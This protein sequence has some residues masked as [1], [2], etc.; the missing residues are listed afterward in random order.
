[1]HR[2]LLPVAARA[3]IGGAGPSGL[4]HLYGF[5]GGGRL[6]FPASS[7]F[8][9]RFGMARPFDALAPATA[10]DLLRCQSLESPPR[11]L[12]LVV[13]CVGVLLGLSDEL[14]GWEGCVKL[15]KGESVLSAG[16]RRGGAGRCAQCSL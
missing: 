9:L 15:L 11:G 8:S 13:G 3:W 14:P 1:M 2:R 4:I 6:P 5:Q 16:A 7:Q 12:V 10:L